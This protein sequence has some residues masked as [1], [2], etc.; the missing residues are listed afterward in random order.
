MVSISGPAWV[1]EASSTTAYIIKVTPPSTSTTVIVGYKTVNGTAISGQDFTGAST[2]AIVTTG[3]ATTP[4]TIAIT[5]DAIDES[6]ENFSVTLTSSDYG[7]LDTRRGRSSPTPRIENSRQTLPRVS[8]VVTCCVPPF[9][10]L[11]RSCSMK[12]SALIP[13]ATP[14]VAVASTVLPYAGIRSGIVST[15]EMV[16]GGHVAAVNPDSS[17]AVP[18]RLPCDLERG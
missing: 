17:L 18:Q 13:K 8:G 1:N 10:T 5:N 9:V 7:T 2:T 3:N 16:V 12:N 15:P 6:D 4:I 11:W 14:L